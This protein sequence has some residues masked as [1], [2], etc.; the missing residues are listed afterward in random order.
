M[1]TSLVEKKPCIHSFVL[2]FNNQSINQS[3]K[4]LLTCWSLSSIVM[5]IQELLSEMK[6]ELVLRAPDNAPVQTGRLVLEMSGRTSPMHEVRM[7]KP[8][9]PLV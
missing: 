3:I 8:V 5:A 6:Q 7:S 9:K 2:L 4:V 1:E